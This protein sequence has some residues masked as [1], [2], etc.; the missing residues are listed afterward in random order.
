MKKANIQTVYSKVIQTHASEDKILKAKNN[1]ENQKK[2]LSKQKND[3]L[4]K[5]KDIRKKENKLADLKKEFSLKL[6]E[7]EKIRHPGVILAG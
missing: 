4:E 6:A 2:K 5:E 3:V 1:T 7:R